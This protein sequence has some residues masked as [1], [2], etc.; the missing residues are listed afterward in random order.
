MNLTPEIVAAGCG[1]TAQLAAQWVAPVQTACDR[2]QIDT[3]LRV[4][5]FLAQC[6]HESAGPART[7][8]SFDYSVAAL[9]QVF[10]RITPALA[11]TLGR[12]PR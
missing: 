11:A 5:A 10:R 3:P 12:R 9:P 4:A 8:E 2:F 1:A 6:G 7:A